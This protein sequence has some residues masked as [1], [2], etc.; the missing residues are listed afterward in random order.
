MVGLAAEWGC[1][2]LVSAAEPLVGLFEQGLCY[3][4]LLFELFDCFLKLLDMG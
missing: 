1:V 3:D 2:Q 4:E